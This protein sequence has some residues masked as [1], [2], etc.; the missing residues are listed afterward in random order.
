MKESTISE[1]EYEVIRCINKEENF[2]QRLIA[3]RTGISLGLTNL[4]IKRLVKKGY[5]KLKQLTPKKIQ[6][7]LTP[8]GMT[9]KIKKSYSFTKR[10]IDTLRDMKQ[11]IQEIILKEYNKGIKKFVI[12]GKGELVNLVEIAIRDLAFNDISY[13]LVSTLDDIKDNNCAIIVS[14]ESPETIIPHRDNRF[15]SKNNKHL[16]NIM[17]VLST[18]KY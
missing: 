1:K 5:L 9:E 8:K 10:T 2:N 12:C 17:K 15:S 16:I 6:Y 14:E 3:D 18:G 13:Y 11:R 4:I 7:L